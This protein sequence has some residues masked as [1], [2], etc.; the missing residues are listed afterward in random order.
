MHI[1]DVHTYTEE[2]INILL[3]HRKKTHRINHLKFKVTTLLMFI[4]LQWNVKGK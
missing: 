1:P 4:S 3:C 2:M